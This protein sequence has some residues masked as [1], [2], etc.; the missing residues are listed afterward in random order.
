MGFGA[1]LITGIPD[2]YPKLGFKR[3]SE[4]GLALS[5]GLAEHTLMTDAFMTYELIPGY[6]NGGGVFHCWPAEYDQA[7]ND[8][9][10]YELFHKQFMAK[11]FPA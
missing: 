6:L 11:F 7:E 1:V 3:A 8:D 2:Y 9:A 4:S 10:G 5:G